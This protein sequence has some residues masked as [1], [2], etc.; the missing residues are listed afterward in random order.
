[1]ATQLSLTKNPVFIDVGDFTSLV[2]ENV[3]QNQI[4][5]SF[6]NDFEDCLLLFEKQTV[7]CSVGIWV[8]TELGG[9]S[10]IRYDRFSEPNRDSIVK[11]VNVQ[12]TVESEGYIGQA[13]NGIFTQTNELPMFD[14][15]LS[16]HVANGWET[17]RFG[18]L[19]DDDYW[20]CSK[21][22]YGVLDCWLVGSILPDNLTEREIIAYSASEGGVKLGS[23][24]IKA[25]DYIKTPK[26]ITKNQDGYSI[27]YEVIEKNDKSYE[28]GQYVD[29]PHNSIPDYRDGVASISLWNYPNN[30]KSVYIYTRLVSEGSL[31]LNKQPAVFVRLDVVIAPTGFD[32]LRGLVK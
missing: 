32:N 30:F 6:S 31:C 22:Y 16:S 3:S 17:L 25:T 11:G 23:I 29:R 26:L 1:M 21:G 27:K 8:W 20:G 14:P 10:L 12:N 15:R 13:R 9:Q 7:S 24:E 5:Y 19:T 18:L 2:L 28:I 4:C